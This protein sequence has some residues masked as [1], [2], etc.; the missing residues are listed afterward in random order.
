LLFLFDGVRLCDQFLMLQITD[1]VEYLFQIYFMRLVQI[2]LEF[3]HDK[4]DKGPDHRSDLIVKL[5]GKLRGL[6]I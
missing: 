3:M 4:F 1:C 6:L 5:K 2:L